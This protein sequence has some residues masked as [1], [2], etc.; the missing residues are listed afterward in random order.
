M[1]CVTDLVAASCSLSSEFLTIV[2]V[3]QAT[4]GCTGSDKGYV[5]GSVLGRSGASFTDDG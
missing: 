2:A 3:M 1:R 4:L 5:E